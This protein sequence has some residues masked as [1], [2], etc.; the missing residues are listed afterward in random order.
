M[1]IT[2][3]GNQY[4]VEKNKLRVGEIAYWLKHL[5]YFQSIQVQFSGLMLGGSLVIP[6][7]GNPTLSYDV[8]GHPPNTFP[9][10]K[11]RLNQVQ[12]QHLKDFYKWS[13]EEQHPALEWVAS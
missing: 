7:P 4:E 9:L 8:W 1:F 5:L 6:A 10:G 2:I 12:K 3:T 13:M 11:N